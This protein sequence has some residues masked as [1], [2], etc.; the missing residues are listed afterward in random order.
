MDWKS[1]GYQMEQGRD[2]RLFDLW[3]VRV[4]AKL[5]FSI[6]IFGVAFVVFQ[7]VISWAVGLISPLVGFALIGYIAIKV[8]LFFARRN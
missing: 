1:V 2:N 5:I 8:L 3:I 6:L 7:T 4:F